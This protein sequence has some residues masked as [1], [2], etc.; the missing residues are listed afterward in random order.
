MHAATR[1][2][3]FRLYQLTN[4]AKIANCFYRKGIRLNLAGDFL[5]FALSIIAN[6]IIDFIASM[7]IISFELMTDRH[8]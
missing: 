1:S 6:S 2:F 8:F 5:S 4:A 3:S 7:P